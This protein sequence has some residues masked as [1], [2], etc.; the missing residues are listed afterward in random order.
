LSHFFGWLRTL[1]DQSYRFFITYDIYFSSSFSSQ[2]HLSY[3]IGRVFNTSLTKPTLPF[4]MRRSGNCPSTRA[5]VVDEKNMRARLAVPV[6]VSFHYKNNPMKIKRIT[7]RKRAG[8]KF[9]P[10]RPRIPIKQTFEEEG[11]L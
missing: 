2:K 10:D 6:P 3:I 1:R 5:H 11:V 9:R 4:L 8:K 7:K